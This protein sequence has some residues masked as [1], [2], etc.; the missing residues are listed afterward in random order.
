MNLKMAVIDTVHLPRTLKTV[1]PK[2]AGLKIVSTKC[3]NS[4]LTSK[5]QYLQPVPKDKISVEE[6]S[7]HSEMH[8]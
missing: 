4:A 8:F 7:V 2:T 6:L 1:K 5:F 3:N